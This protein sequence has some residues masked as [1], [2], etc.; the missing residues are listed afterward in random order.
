VLVV[1]DDEVLSRFL[2]RIL[3]KEGAEVELA[4][5]GDAALPLLRP[6]LDA[7]ILDLN[8]PGMD[9]ITLLRKLRAVFGALSVLVL[10]ARARAESAVL[11]LE[12]GADDCLT[13]PFSYVELLAR[14]RV[15]FRRHE[16]VTTRRIHCG[17]LLLDRDE[18]RVMR[19]DR[20]VDLTPREYSLLEFLLRSPGI[21]VSRAVLLKELWGEDG[22]SNSNVIDVYMKYLRDKIDLPGL[23]K[24]IRTVR[25][26]GYAICES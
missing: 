4:H 13:K 15:L 23:P 26:V 9:G 7:V 6:E 25:G 19:Q 20:R 12:N 14:L 1:E 22:N 3:R 21:P 17:S 10:T 2:D 16:R 11:A 8:L 5:S 24:L 18:L